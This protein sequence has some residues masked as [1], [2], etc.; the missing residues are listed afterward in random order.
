MAQHDMVVEN[1]TGRN[2]RLDINDALAA[3]VSNNSGDTEPAATFPFMWW[4][5]SSGSDPILKFRNEANDG[6]VEFG[7]IAPNLGALLKSGGTMTGNLLF[8]DGTTLSALP[9]AFDGDPDTG[10]YRSAANI[11]HLVAA[12]ASLLTID[13]VAGYIKLL[14]TKALQL[15]IGTTA[16]RP[17]GAEGLLRA[18]STTKKFEG[19][20]NGGWQSLNDFSAFT[21]IVGSAAYCTHATLA[22]AIADTT[23]VP[24]GSIILLTA[25]ETLNSTVTLGLANLTIVA[26]PGV[27]LT[28]G[29]AGTG[30]EIGATGCRIRGVR[31]SGFTTAISISA[32]YQYNFVTECRFASCT[33]DIVE[34]DSAPVN[35]LAN[36]LNE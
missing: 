4:V 21:A 19:Y 22:A 32:T 17:T 3:L 26:L 29:S 7:V 28:N 27:T 25:N 6:W 15:A 11:W 24:A 20:I 13:G 2:V 8:D 16:E 33:S 10:F 9:A 30:I 1:N 36:N 34:V 23:N 14:G 35:V 12:G 31:F 5:D 18:N